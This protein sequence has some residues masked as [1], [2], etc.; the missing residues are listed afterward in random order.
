MHLGHI[1]PFTVTKQ[2]VL[3][4]GGIILTPNTETR[5][6]QDVF[7]VTLVIIVTDDEKY[8]PRKQ[9]YKRDEIRTFENR[10][11]RD[12]LANGF[13]FKKTFLFCDFDFMEGS[14]YL[15]VVKI[16]RCITYDTSKAVFGFTERSE[17]AFSDN[18]Q[19]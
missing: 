5:W 19:Q 4:R 12:I 14:L 3:L 7:D 17:T 11:A 6:L 18:S 13:D 8:L 10:N 16:S 15:N 9:V 2:V 1:V